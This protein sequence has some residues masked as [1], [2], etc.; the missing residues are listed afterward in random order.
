LRRE[1]RGRRRRRGSRSWLLGRLWLG[2]SLVS[3]GRRHLVSW[4]HVWRLAWSHSY[5]HWATWMGIRT[6]SWLGNEDRR[7]CHH[8][9]LRRTSN[10]N[11]TWRWP[12][13]HH[14]HPHRRGRH[15]VRRR[16]GV[17]TEG[18]GVGTLHAGVRVR[19]GVRRVGRGRKGRGERG[20]GDCVHNHGGWASGGTLRRTGGERWLRTTVHVGFEVFHVGTVRS[21]CSEPVRLSGFRF[22]L[23]RLAFHRVSVYFR[24]GSRVGN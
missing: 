15:H 14:A 12:H 6:H 10:S 9:S 1:R 7:T 18:H 22:V 5:R 21:T 13:V 2:W 4:V 23:M 11:S 8:L 3:N 24:N 19:R 20:E 17:S 16:K